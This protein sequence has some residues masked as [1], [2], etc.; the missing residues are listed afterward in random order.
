[1]PPEPVA[2]ALLGGLGFASAPEE[3]E[4]V[5]KY[6]CRATVR[7]KPSIPICMQWYAVAVKARAR[8][9]QGPRIIALCARMRTAV[10]DVGSAW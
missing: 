5:G 1:M 6:M 7:G 3:Q 2:V 10:E 8:Y 9:E 4:E